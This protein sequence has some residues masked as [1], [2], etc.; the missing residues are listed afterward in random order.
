MIS[1]RCLPALFSV[2]YSSWLELDIRPRPYSPRGASLS[3][4]RGWAASRGCASGARRARFVPWSRSCF[5][6]T[7]SSA[8]CVLARSPA[9]SGKNGMKPM[10]ARRNSR[11][12]LRA[13]ID[14]IVAVL[15]RRHLEHFRRL[16]DVADR[17]SLRPACRMIPS[18]SKRF[19]GAELFAR[20]NM[21]I[22]AV[23]LPKVDLLYTENFAG[24]GA[25]AR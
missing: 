11:A 18:S 9:A 19:D 7:W 16:F 25:P 6:A 23:K 24:C 13:P 10:P 12:P 5:F 8:L 22:D 20:R 4:C 15:H 1:A 3:T 2:S 14:N 21:R 17:T